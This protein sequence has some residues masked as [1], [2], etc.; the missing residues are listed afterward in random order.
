MTNIVK[1]ENVFE[2]FF[3]NSFFLKLCDLNAGRGR[4]DGSEEGG[5]EAT[6]RNST[7][8]I[9]SSVN[10]GLLEFIFISTHH[11]RR[12]VKQ[13]S[14]FS[15]SFARCSKSMKF[16]IVKHTNS[17]KVRLDHHSSTSCNFSPSSTDLLPEIAA[18]RNH[19]AAQNP[20]KEETPEPPQEPMVSL[21]YSF[22]LR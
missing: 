14:S 15:I 4:S 12:I 6:A 19:I 5:R 9:S 8:I 13:C 16:I 11:F 1:L 7:D 21:N 17:S 20:S 10:Y 22:L 2:I 3:R 18:V